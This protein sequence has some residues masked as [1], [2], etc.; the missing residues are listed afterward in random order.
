MKASKVLFIFF[1]MDAASASTPT[2]NDAN[3]LEF[4]SKLEEQRTKKMVLFFD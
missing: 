2:G 4:E 1:T 3:V